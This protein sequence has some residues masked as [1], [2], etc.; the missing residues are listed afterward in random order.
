MELFRIEVEEVLVRCDG[1]AFHIASC[2]VEQGVDASEVL[3]DV[4]TV[5]FYQF[6]IHHVGLIEFGDAAFVSD[7]FHD[8]VAYLFLTSEDS[9]LG[10][11][12]CEVLANA[13]TKDTCAAGDDDNIAFN[14]E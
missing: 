8:L 4:L 12:L 9:D 10:S 5:L 2:G 13:A 6:D 3:E 11:L 1:G 7:L 14:V